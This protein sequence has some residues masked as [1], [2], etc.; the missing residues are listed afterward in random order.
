MLTH[1]CWIDKYWSYIYIVHFSA[2]ESNRG[3]TKDMWDGILWL[4][5]KMKPSFRFFLLFP[6]I[7]HRKKGI[8]W[9]S[10]LLTN[11]PT[12]SEW[13]CLVSLLHYL[14]KFRLWDGTSSNVGCT[15]SRSAGC[16]CGH[17]ELPQFQAG[18]MTILLSLLKYHLFMKV[19]DKFRQ[20]CHFRV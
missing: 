2:A 12:I 9:F 18:K 16:K 19:W 15:T 7:S 20:P 11:M 17:W 6:K 1:T 8:K 4:S 3:E 14:C 13:L 5:L 10:G